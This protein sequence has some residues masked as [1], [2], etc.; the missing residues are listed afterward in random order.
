[1]A[2]PLKIDTGTSPVSLKE[3]SDAD[4]DY[5]TDVIL[6]YFAATSTGV[7]TVGTDATKTL[8]GTFTDTYLTDAV[9]THPTAGTVSSTVYNF[10]Q[11]L[12]SA[13][14]SLVRPVHFDG[15][16]SIE[17]VDATL[18][19]T[20]IADAQSNL[21]NYGIGSY[22]LQPTAPAG[23]TWTAE[24]TIT[25]TRTDGTAATTYLW[26]KTTDTAPSTVRTVK[27]NSTTPKSL[28]EMSDAEIQTLTARL[29]NQIV[30]NGIGQ[31]KV[32]ASTPVGGTW[33]TRGTAFS[34]TRKDISSV[35]YSGTYNTNDA[36]TYSSSFAGT[37]SQAFAGAYTLYYA[38][39]VGGYFTGY[40]T[41]YFTGYY[42]S[43]FT[44]YYTGQFTGNYS[45]D[46]V[47]STNSVISTVSLWIRTA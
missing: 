7:G 47:Q 34:D 13:A 46:T 22:V 38:G 39:Y 9:G 6:K 25:D 26:R 2:R 23:G 41:G 29:R 11:D 27:I 33:V 17:Q 43:N 36:G 31:Y 4:Y 21:V 45:G 1:M 37:Y 24:R 16:D 42:T 10:Y 15:T 18:N 8:I 30:S 12:G 19:S 20:L 44:G 3:M 5:P 32:Q 40:Y 14:E 28:K 35:S